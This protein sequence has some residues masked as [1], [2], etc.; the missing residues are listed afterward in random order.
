[1]KFAFA[2]LVT[3]ATTTAFTGP[4]ARSSRQTTSAVVLQAAVRPDTSK[5]IQEALAKS[6]QF[7]PTSTEARLAW[8][9]VEE[10]DA[11]TNQL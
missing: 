6:K 5:I 2:F 3:F 10:M 1:M 9:A 7:G 4:M 8:E 11:S